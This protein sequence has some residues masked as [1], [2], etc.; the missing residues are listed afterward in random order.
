[1]SSKT[2]NIEDKIGEQSTTEVS[3]VKI[4]YKNLGS[5]YVV[6]A[7]QDSTTEVP[8][9]LTGVDKVISAIDSNEIDASVDLKGLTEGEHTVKVVATGNDNR[10]T[11][12]SKIKEIKLLIIKK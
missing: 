10:V 12:K 3:G 2:V 9:I 1:M 8:V 4:S 5:D 11:Y 7:T 6:Q